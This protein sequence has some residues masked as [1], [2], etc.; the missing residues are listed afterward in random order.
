MSDGSWVYPLFFWNLSISV[1]VSCTEFGPEAVVIRRLLF[2][3]N[4]GCL[5]GADLLLI[6]PDVDVPLGVVC[7]VFWSEEFE[8]S[9]YISNA[10]DLQLYG[11]L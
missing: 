2:L 10:K 5:R 3:A 8:S 6:V 11:T 7:D 9:M 4:D 1:R